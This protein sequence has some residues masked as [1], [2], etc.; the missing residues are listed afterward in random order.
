MGLQA[1]VLTWLL[2]YYPFTSLT[3]L[4]LYIGPN[5]TDGK[6]SVYTCTK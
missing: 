4:D 6:N 3:V 2:T 1:V 5:C